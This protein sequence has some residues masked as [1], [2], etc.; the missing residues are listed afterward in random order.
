MACQ[1]KDYVHNYSK[2]TFLIY[3]LERYIDQKLNYLTKKNIKIK[4]IGNIN[5]FPKTLKNKLRVVQKKTY[6]NNKIQINIALNYGSKQEILNSAKKT[7]NMT[8]LRL[9]RK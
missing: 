5:K 1:S 6:E 9:S 7:K 8:N 3:L 4:I 2:L